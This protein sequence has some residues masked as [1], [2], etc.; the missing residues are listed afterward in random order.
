MSNTTTDHQ[1]EIILQFL[2]GL[3]ECIDEAPPIEESEIIRVFLLN[4]YTLVQVEQEVGH[5][6]KLSVANILSEREMSLARKADRLM[7]R[8]PTYSTPQIFHAGIAYSEEEQK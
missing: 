6:V 3:C 4:L 7:P 2:S 8:K 5:P 1:Y